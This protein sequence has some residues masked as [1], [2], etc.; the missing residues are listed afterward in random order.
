MHKTLNEALKAAH[1]E[2]KEIVLDS[3]KRFNGLVKN[4][5]VHMYQMLQELGIK[6]GIVI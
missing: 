4:T 6:K 1:K 5:E 3:V 2:L